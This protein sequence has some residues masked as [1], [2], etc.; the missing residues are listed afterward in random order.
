MKSRIVQSDGNSLRLEGEFDL[1]NAPE[2]A[3]AIGQ[4]SG[5]GSVDVDLSRVTFMDTSGLHAL[6]RGADSLDGDTSVVLVDPPSS[7]V[8]M[9]EIVGLT[10]MRQ[11]EI[12]SRQD[13]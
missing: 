13:G 3:A 5:D 10:R 7:I 6:I 2:V 9:M 4:L 1:A 8:R 11:V 12:R